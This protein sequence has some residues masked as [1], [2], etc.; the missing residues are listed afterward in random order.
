MGLIRDL[1]RWL[2]TTPSERAY[3]DA[4]SDRP[5]ISDADFYQRFYADSEVTLE[6][7]AGV[8]RVLCHQLGMCNTLPDDNVAL[9]FGDIDIADVCFALGEEFDVTFPDDRFHGIDG[10]V[11]SLIRATQLLTR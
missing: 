4:I 1:F 8:R 9:V 5:A 6:T 11:N 3:F 7:C 10:T 2:T